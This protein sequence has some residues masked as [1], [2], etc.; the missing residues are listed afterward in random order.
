M[1]VHHVVLASAAGA[2][3][4]VPGA[5]AADMPAKARPYA[6]PP[7]VVASWTGMYIGVHVGGASV[8]GTIFDDPYN[9]VSFVGGGQIGYNWQM[10]NFVFG[11]EA[12]GS[13]LSGKSE[14]TDGPFTY[15]THLPW[16]STVRGRFGMAFG[17]WL[18]YVTAGVAFSKIKGNYDLVSFSSTKTGWALGGGLEHMLTRNWVIGAE[19]LFVDFGSNT[20]TNNGK[21]I[22]VSN[23]AL[24]GR[25]KLNYKF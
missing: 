6:A 24:I 3:A 22:F 25:A 2:A 19:V 17:N 7:P 15:G 16:L 18:A 13:W 8:R 11:V 14:I 5:Q 4:F 12:D 1:K 21:S 9:N 20:L 10:G 23:S